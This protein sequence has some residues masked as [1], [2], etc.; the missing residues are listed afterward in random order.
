MRGEGQPRGE[1]GTKGQRSWVWSCA[2]I[3]SSYFIF[4]GPGEPG[5]LDEAPTAGEATYAQSSHD[6]ALLLAP[7]YTLFL[8]TLNC[9]TV[10][11]SHWI[12]LLLEGETYC[13][14]KV[15]MEVQISSPPQ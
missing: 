3:I 8:P 15:L 7:L 9:F 14:K 10:V 5:H 2:A 4:A 1:V 6:T 13:Y 12:S 11:F